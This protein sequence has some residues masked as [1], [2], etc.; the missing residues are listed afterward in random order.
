MQI[1]LIGYGKMGKAIEGLLLECGHSVHSK[2]SSSQAPTLESLKGADVAI[3][4]SS[5]STAVENVAICFSANVPVVVGT[6]GWYDQIENV[7]TLQIKQNAGVF[8]A[9]NFSIGVHI[10]QHVNAQLA[11]LMN[12]FSEY[13][14]SIHE[15]H[16]LQKLDAPSGTAITTAD[17]MLKE[18]NKYSNWT[19]NHPVAASEVSISSARFPDVKGTHEIKY[20]SEI[21]TIELRHEAHSRKGF[22][23]G[24][25][26]AAEWMINKKGFFSMDD[27]LNINRL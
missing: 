11:K 26:K 21:D 27:M 17:V 25:I 12:H 15:I 18:L 19:V 24:A 6:T 9:S 8:V 1:A 20:T 4:F 13:V 10:F 14:P 5:P 16:H 23:L 7:K 22:A 2:Y 3:E